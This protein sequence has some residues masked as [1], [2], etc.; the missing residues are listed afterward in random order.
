MNAVSTS[1]SFASRG[2]AFTHAL[3]MEALREQV[4][5]AGAK[6]VSLAE[7]GVL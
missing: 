1:M 6:V 5:V 2:T 3:S 7:R 4:I